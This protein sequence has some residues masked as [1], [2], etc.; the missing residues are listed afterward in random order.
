MKK[1]E[2]ILDE[3]ILMRKKGMFYYQISEKTGVSATQICRLIKDKISLPT[4]KKYKINETVFDKIDTE[5]K[6]Y[7]LGFFAADGYISPL[8]SLNITLARKDEE[9]LYKFLSFLK[10]NKKIKRYENKIG[11]KTYY[12][13][14]VQVNSMYI[15]KRLKDIG[16]NNN[17]TYDL[18]YPVEIMDEY[19]KDF[20][21][22]MFDGDGSVGF[23]KNKKKKQQW[24][25]SLVGNAKIIDSFIKF[26]KR[27]INTGIKKIEKTN[28]KGIFSATLEG[29][30]NVRNF[31]KLLYKDCEVFLD[32]KKI[33]FEN[34]LK[35]DES[36]K[37]YDFVNPEISPSILE[38]MYKENG[39][40]W[41]VVAK[42]LGVSRSW[43]NNYR[44][45]N[46][47][48]HTTKYN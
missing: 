14:A 25:V 31:Y 8:G 44:F 42:K 13:S 6:A 22:G 38:R 5:E 41:E 40:R 32:R 47:M 7:W 11:Q 16:L 43:V 37:K 27:H 23:Y 15:Q 2:E 10:S 29:R 9:H 45:K 3:L 20:W 24:S 21:R 19:E 33:I 4:Y 18:T 26:I 12:Q 30:N 34:F 39:K 1:G 35:Y 17:K 28:S 48:P 36:Q 46:K